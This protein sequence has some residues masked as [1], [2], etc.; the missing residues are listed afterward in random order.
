MYNN[1]KLG[2]R[3]REKQ[4]MNPTVY[5]DGKIHSE[6]RYDPEQALFHLLTSVPIG[7]AMNSLGIKSATQKTGSATR[8]TKV[9]SRLK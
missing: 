4:G 1:V 5:S 6:C 7:P 8:I 9:Y 2:Q 3:K